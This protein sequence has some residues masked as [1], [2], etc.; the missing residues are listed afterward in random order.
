MATSQLEVI[1][2]EL[3]RLVDEALSDIPPEAGINLEDDALFIDDLHVAMPVMRTVDSTDCKEESI[4]TILS[5]LEESSPSDSQLLHVEGYL[6]DAATITLKR[7][8]IEKLE[9]MEQ[10]ASSILKCGVRVDGHHENT[11][12]EGANSHKRFQGDFGGTAMQKGFYAYSF[13]TYKF[14]VVRC[15]RCMGPNIEPRHVY[16]A[17][18]RLQ[19]LGEIEL[20][21]DTTSNGRAM[22]LRIARDGINTFRRKVAASNDQIQEAYNIDGPV[23]AL[24]TKFSKQFAAKE[25]ASVGKVKS[26]HDIIQQVSRMKDTEGPTNDDNDAVLDEGGDDDD[27]MRILPSKKSN[28]LLLFQRLVQSYFRDGDIP[29]DAPNQ[30]SGIIKNFPL[31]NMRLLMCLSSD[32]SSLMQVLAQRR[33]E[34]MPMAVR[35]ED[36]SF[37]D[38][39]DLCIAKILHSIDAPRAPILDWYSHPLWGKY[40]TYS[41]S[42]VVQA[43]KKSFEVV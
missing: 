16:A 7:R 35:I 33:Q 43:V 3:Q 22:H 5:L 8:S 40:R 26:M 38:Y 27:S 28:R 9:K 42:S 15:A 23:R 31:Q 14:S 2:L 32:V 39:R 29:G 13:G 18:R 21:L 6:P 12:E 17:L 37:A 1:F 34:Q 11:N 30:S 20:V 41:F 36:P 24:V 10:I 4:E 25:K 19:Q